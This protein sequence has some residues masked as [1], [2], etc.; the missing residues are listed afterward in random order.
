MTRKFTRGDFYGVKPKAMT[1]KAQR[2]LATIRKKLASMGD[3]WM[4]IDP[5]VE[6]QLDAVLSAIDAFSK[7]LD[8]SREYLTEAID[9]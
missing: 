8:D 2:Q 4:D 3:P 9:E 5:T 1:S 7:C 6:T